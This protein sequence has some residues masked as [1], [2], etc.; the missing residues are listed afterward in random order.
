MAVAYGLREGGN[1]LH[2]GQE[3]RALGCGQ[4]SGLFGNPH[5]RRHQ[6][7]LGTAHIGTGPHGHAH[8][9]GKA[10]IHQDNAHAI[11]KHMLPPRSR[12][13]DSA[14]PARR[15]IRQKMT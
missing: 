15:K 5:F 8:I 2:P 9:F 1:H 10:R 11:E 6:G 12:G 3:G 14:G 7:E 13:T 4:R